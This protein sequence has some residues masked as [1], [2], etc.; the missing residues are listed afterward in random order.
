[1]SLDNDTQHT[2]AAA[3]A[4]GVA[5]RVAQGVGFVALAV[6][7]AQL[8]LP[9]IAARVV[10]VRPRRRTASAVRMLGAG[11][12]AGGAAVLGTS[13]AMARATKPAQMITRAV[14]IAC[15]PAEIRAALVESPLADLDNLLDETP[16]QLRT[17]PGGR[18]TEVI[19]RL[20]HRASDVGAIRAL[21]KLFGKDIAQ[22][23]GRALARLKQRLETGT[24]ARS[25]AS[26]HS[27]MHAARPTSSEETRT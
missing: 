3:R 23:L 24:E 26:I 4:R 10:G 8:L 25:D 20:H 27:G 17:A 21:R 12:I 14:T 5:R 22:E 6:G 1:M 18:G 19:V 13:Y 15:T 16:V 11:V 9:R 7:A 2:M